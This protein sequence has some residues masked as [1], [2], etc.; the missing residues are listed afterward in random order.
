M[1]RSPLT[2][3]AQQQ[4]QQQQQE[5]QQQNAMQQQQQHPQ[6]P[7]HDAGEQQRARPLLPEAL[8]PAAAVKTAAVTAAVDAAAV[9][10]AAATRAAAAGLAAANAAA[11]HA[12][13]ATAD[14][15]RAIDAAA[16]AAAAAATLRKEETTS[17]TAAASGAA[18]ASAAAPG[19]SEG[20]LADEGPVDG[21][22]RP[23][24]AAAAAAAAVDARCPQP[25]DSS[26]G[27]GDTA[28]P[29][30]SGSSSSE[31]VVS[32][33][34]VSPSPSVSSAAAA[35]AA[36]AT[37]AAARQRYA[38]VRLNMGSSCD[39]RLVTRVALLSPAE[40]IK[41]YVN[42]C[43]LPLLQQARM[44]Q[45]RLRMQQQQ[46]PHRKKP[47]LLHLQEAEEAAEAAP[48]G[49]E[50]E[51]SSAEQKQQQQEEQQEEQQRERQDPEEHQQQQQECLHP[52]NGLPLQCRRVKLYE[53]D[54]E[55]GNWLDR[56]TGHFYVVDGDN[57][58]IPEADAAAAASGSRLIVQ[59]E[60]TDAFVVE[61]LI[62]SN[63]LYQHQ[64]ESIITWQEGR[65]GDRYRA[66]SFQHPHGCFALW[67]YIYLLSPDCCAGSMSD[68]EA[69]EEEEAEAEAAAAAAAA[70]GAA[71]A[72]GGAAAA[73]GGGG[74]L[75]EQQQEDAERPTRVLEAPTVSSLPLLVQRL[76]FDLQHPQAN[77]QL[78]QDIR[79]R[80]WLRA[81][82]ALMRQQMKAAKG[83]EETAKE[84][85]V[86][87][88]T[89]GTDHGDSS[90]A[91]GD[92]PSA[93]EAAAAAQA[94][95]APA[96]AAAAA[97]AGENLKQMAF[98][99]RKMLVAW[100][101]QIEALEIFL[102]GE[103]WLDVLQ[104]LE[105]E[106]D[107]VSQG[108]S[109]PHT[110][111]FRRVQFRQ[112]LPLQQQ[113]Q[114]QE[115]FLQHVHLHYRLTYLRDVALTRYVDEA[116]IAQLQ[117]LL[118]SNGHTIICL[119]SQ[120][121]PL[122]SPSSPRSPLLSP[123]SAAAATAAA[124]GGE[125]FG[126][127]SSSSGTG[128]SSALQLLKARLGTDYYC[129]LFL[130]ELLAL[131]QRLTSG[132]PGMLCA[133]FGADGGARGFRG[134]SHAL[135]GL[136]HQI[137]STG[138]LLELKGYLRGDPEAMQMWTDIILPINKKAEADQ[139]QLVSRLLA[140]PH[141]F[142]RPNPLDFESFV[143]PH[144]LTVS[145]EILHIFAEIQPPVFRQ[146]LFLE[147]AAEQQQQQQQQQL[148]LLL[149]RVLG[150]AESLSVQVMVKDIL[151][152][153]VC[154]VNMELPEKDEINTLFFDRGVIE[155]LLTLLFKP[156]PDDAPAGQ[157][158][159]LA[160]AKQ[161]VLEIFSHCVAIHRHRFKVRI[162]RDN[163]PLRALLTAVTP[164][165][166]KFLS[167]FAVK[168]VRACVCLRDAYVDK[169]LV[170]SKA[171]R[172]IIWM[173]KA[174]MRIEDYLAPLPSSR[175]LGGSLLTCAILDCLSCL[176]PSAS[177]LG[178]G[179]LPAHAGGGGAGGPQ[180]AGS[181]LVE[182]LFE[183]E[184]TS[185]WIEQ[186][187]GAVN[188]ARK[189]R[190]PVLR[191]LRAHYR[192]LCLAARRDSLQVE[193]GEETANTQQPHQLS[194]LGRII[195]ADPHRQVVDDDDSWFFNSRLGLGFGVFVCRPRLS[196]VDG[197]DDE[198]EQQQQ[199]QQQGS[200]SGTDLWAGS[201]GSSSSATAAAAKRLK[202]TRRRR[203]QRGPSRKEG[204][205]SSSSSS[206]S[207]SDDEKPAKYPP[208]SSSS[209]GSSAGDLD[210]DQ[211]D[212]S[213]LSVFPEKPVAA[214]GP[215]AA[216]LRG[217]SSPRAAAAAAAAA[218]QKKRIAVKIGTRPSSSEAGK[219]STT[220]SS[221]SSSSST[222]SIASPREESLV[223]GSRD[224]GAGDRGD[225]PRV[226]A[227]P[228]PGE[229]NA[230]SEGVV[231]LQ[232]VLQQSAA[233][234]APAAAAASPAAAKDEAQQP[235]AAAAAGR[236]ESSSCHLDLIRD[237]LDGPDSDEEKP[238][239]AAPAAAAAA[240]AE[241]EASPSAAGDPKRRRV[242]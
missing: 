83:G 12:A 91:A 236:K 16:D 116:S 188:R 109:L 214:V 170:K 178:L 165:F 37:A 96:A 201:S 24:A 160:H 173:L 137:K 237:L 63:S 192:R 145:V 10:A 104:C 118:L 22:L 154:G 52:V 176:I 103:F 204:D 231:L 39:E 216:F 223:Q 153:V 226:A 84:Q 87:E 211:P 34:S 222:S 33:R 25:S 210:E 41:A 128:G 139:Q 43:F 113:Q 148:L 19:V 179:C 111:F 7:K 72:A 11:T 150:T 125:A 89:Q 51:A 124:G 164:K 228:S 26:A 110:A 141:I 106:D 227:A 147:A 9:D 117:S 36:A 38:A 28:A 108:M 183:D 77:R 126:G 79:N 157:Q 27:N 3:E 55:T 54:G 220:D 74:W 21:L 202:V 76:E 119:L 107:L 151:L 47:L 197:Y 166:D 1:Q 121:S 232:R 20:P 172:P 196:L 159:Q 98:I 207:S 135:Y 168:F 129:L 58:D 59:E 193:S 31:E 93:A 238:A 71:A 185:T 112:V 32:A 155:C 144:P 114:Q 138:L 213:L 46:Q 42:G 142:H 68:E 230:L 23:A 82:F 97:A 127:A 8:E 75:Q 99:I 149:C 105:F 78:L 174:R 194:S 162:F 4:Q 234:T 182:F 233:H 92:S 53:V 219:E 45:Q 136:F 195:R 131:L 143:Y 241:R 86:K 14:A 206:S 203:Q 190:C 161:M 2:T 177:S 17:P 62:C 146:V 48:T 212:E 240:A 215:P 156:L 184:F 56:G 102:S 132:A 115:L 66:L 15:A 65:Q 57:P 90:S 67:T 30:A 242:N 100:A 95:A 200:A 209:R 158:Q 85:A 69:D 186:V 40:D 80:H 13:T 122:Q 6:Q 171:F 181:P 163:V 60:E 88:E 44:Q 189:N 198:E 224:S 70:D 169:H 61:S 191:D 208:S 18:A 140:A 133:P 235:A 167:L 199:Q 134:P 81:F 123:S 120:A 239:A 180:G 152:K 35:A 50:D 101:G 49:G 29:S 5:P 187:E 217:P 175:R 221:S 229:D 73:R 218:K 205:S 130:R 225:D 94:A 64:K